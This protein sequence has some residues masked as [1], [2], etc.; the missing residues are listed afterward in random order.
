MLKESIEHSFYIMKNHRYIIYEVTSI[1][2]FR[3]YLSLLKMLIRNTFNSYTKS[4]YI[5][6]EPPS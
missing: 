3:T 5:N 1:S 2:R 4:P 6:L